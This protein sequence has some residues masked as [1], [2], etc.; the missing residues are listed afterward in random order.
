MNKKITPGALFA[1]TEGT[2]KR[3]FLVCISEE[4][5]HYNFLFLPDLD[6][7]RIS[8]K[9]VVDG[10]RKKILEFIEILPADVFTICETQYDKNSN[11]RLVKPSI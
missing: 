7:C 6:P 8:S 10:V 3:K 9:D 2:Y 4:S 5:H 11:T 1:V